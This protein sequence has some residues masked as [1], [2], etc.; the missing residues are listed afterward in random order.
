MDYFGKSRS[1]LIKAVSVLSP[2]GWT[3]EVQGSTET[4]ERYPTY[5]LTLLGEIMISPIGAGT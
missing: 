2:C 1:T 3:G 5:C 4:H